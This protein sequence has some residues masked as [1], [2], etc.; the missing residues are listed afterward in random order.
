MIA[1]FYYLDKMF[2]FELLCEQKLFFIKISSR[3]IIKLFAQNGSKN[4][5]SV[6]TNVFRLLV[7]MTFGNSFRFCT[8]VLPKSAECLE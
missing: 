7:S 1:S 6:E 2:C 4:L 5:A 8:T 3:W